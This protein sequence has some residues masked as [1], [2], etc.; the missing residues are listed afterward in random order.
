MKHN[1]VKA[2][3]KNKLKEKFPAQDIVS[4]DETMSSRQIYFV[5]KE[6]MRV[7][8]YLDC[9]FGTNEFSV[10]AF[11]TSP[12]NM[13]LGIKPHK[14][15]DYFKEVRGTYLQIHLLKDLIEDIKKNK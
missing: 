9:F 15:K 4:I 2:Y 1:E 5:D 14:Y 7:W 6:T 12:E 3:F 10:R 13:S 8:I 11:R